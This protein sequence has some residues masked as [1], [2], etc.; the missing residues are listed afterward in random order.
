MGRTATTRQMVQPEFGE[1]VR[2]QRIT[3]PEGQDGPTVEQPQIDD[4]G[5]L[6]QKIDAQ[7]QFIASGPDCRTGAG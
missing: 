7:T 3:A 2:T 5:T 1:T 6:R 4:G